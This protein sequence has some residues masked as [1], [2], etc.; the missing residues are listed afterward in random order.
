MALGGETCRKGCEH[1]GL[2][3]SGTGS[4]KFWERG[5]LA[6]SETNAYRFGTKILTE[7]LLELFEEGPPLRS[8]EQPIRPEVFG[9]LNTDL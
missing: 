4:N 7:V 9:M 2:C 1:F 3:G 8:S 5:T 6:S